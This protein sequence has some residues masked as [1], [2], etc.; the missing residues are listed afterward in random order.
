MNYARFEPTPPECVESIKE[1]IQ[2]KVVYDFGAG[3]GEFSKVMANLYAKKVIGIESDESMLKKYT[4][5]PSNCEMWLGDF[6]QRD[7]SQVEVIYCF[8]S[9]V[10]IDR[11]S[12]V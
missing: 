3:D 8:L 10:G 4:P 2:D 12:V 7:L 6:M 9:F 1:F 5:G 11:K